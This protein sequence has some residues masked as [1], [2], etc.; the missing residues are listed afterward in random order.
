V[1]VRQALLYGKGVIYQDVNTYSINYIDSDTTFCIVKPTFT[2]LN[3]IISND[4]L[5]YIGTKSNYIFL[6]KVVL[7]T[8]DIAEKIQ[9]ESPKIVAYPHLVSNRFIAVPTKDGLHIIPL[10]D[11]ASMF[12]IPNVASPHALDM[13]DD[14]IVLLK[15]IVQNTQLHFFK[16][17]T[18]IS[19]C[20]LDVRLMKYSSTILKGRNV[21][22][23]SVRNDS[24]IVKRM[25]CSEEP[26]VVITLIGSNMLYD[27]SD[28][29]YL[30]KNNRTFLVKELLP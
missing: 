28:N 24:T 23:S 10:G 18:L 17:D 14:T 8:E 20:K 9:I 7:F 15:D 4:T 19:M 1:A 27:V 6:E 26:E 16:K 21:Y 30:F 12:V 11:Y 22:H 29:K 5:F 3:F 2:V 13:V 25:A